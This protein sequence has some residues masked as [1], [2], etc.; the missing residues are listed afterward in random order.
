MED[1]VYA[2][3]FTGELGRYSLANGTARWKAPISTFHT[4]TFSRSHLFTIDPT[5]KLMAVNKANGKLR[6]L[7]NLSAAVKALD[8]PTYSVADVFWY[9]PLLVSGKLFVVN[10]QGLSYIINPQTG[11]VE[12]EFE[13]PF[14]VTSNPI[15]VDN[16]MILQS[17]RGYIYVY[18]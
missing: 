10:D 6:W 3:S 16:K 11:S 17:S 15:V 9:R 14:K 18:E 4:P 13:F 8:A 7:L 1:S 5:G 12:K 2:S